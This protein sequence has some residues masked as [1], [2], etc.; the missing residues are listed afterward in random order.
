MRHPAAEERGSVLQRRLINHDLRALGFDA[1]HHALDAALSEI[2][3]ARL[4]RQAI[5]ADD[6]VLFTAGFI[7]VVIRVVI[8]SRFMKHAIR[9][10][11]LSRA[12][13]FHN[14]PDQLFRHIL[15]VRQ[16]LLGILEQAVAAIHNLEDTLEIPQ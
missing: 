10:E 11:V 8:V 7:F 9:D 12:V 4:H 3:A 2:I 15:I 1:L 13:G 6:D 16:Q 14:G 5:D